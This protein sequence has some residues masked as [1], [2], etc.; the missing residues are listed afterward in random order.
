MSVNVKSFFKNALFLLV[1]LMLSVMVGFALI[2]AVYLL[3]VDSIRTHVEASSSVYDK[4]GLTRLYIPWLTSTR[5]D[6]YTDAIMLSEAAYHGDEP[7][8]SQAL[9]S[10]YIYVTEPSLYSEPGY[11]NR[12][13]EPSSDGTSAKVSYSRYWHGY[14]VLLKPILMIFDI[15]GIRVINGLFQI[16]M[17]C[18]VLR[19]LYLCMGTRRLFIPMV[20]TVLAINPLSTALNM[21]YATIYSIALMG[22]YVI[23][24]WKLY[25][26]INVWRVFLFIGVSVAFFDFL[27]YPL[28]SL[29]V[30]LII[31]LCARN[32]DSI[33]NIK[34]VL[35]SSLFWGIG[36]AFMWISKWVI[37]D[38]LLGTNTI[39]DAINQVM[40]RTVTDA[41]EETGIESGNIIDVIGYNVEAFR[42]YLSLGALILS[43]IVF[44]GYLVLTKKR[45]KIEE[46]L[47][48]SLLLIA[49]MPFIWYTVLSNHSAIH[50]W[51][52]YRNLAVTILSLGAIMVKGISDRETSNPDML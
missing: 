39:N 10:N 19:E 13:L 31:V 15:T 24:H 6:N 7:V 2:S 35:L 1:S 50:F 44:V 45:F 27:T 23:M 43:I 21:Q 37:T 26:S 22:I 11:L 17:L 20:I 28:V 14:L 4:E 42:D 32:K 5:M 40:I 18:L 12:M 36:Y 52:T 46:N 16:V 29:G 30:P 41:Y 3:P 8:I 49:L 9:Q 33:E 38:V 51:M 25:E 34:T 47:L 48:L